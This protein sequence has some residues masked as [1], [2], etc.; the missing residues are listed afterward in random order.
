MERSERYRFGRFA[1]LG[2]IAGVY[3]AVCMALRAVFWIVDGGPSL[4][5]VGTALG[6]FSVGLLYDLAALAWIAVPFTLSALAWPDGRRGRIGHAT[7][8]VCLALG[9]AVG[10]AL[11]STGEVLFWNEFAARFNFIGVDYLV[12]TKEVTGNIAQSYPIGWLLAGALGAAAIVGGGLVPAVWRRARRRGPRLR[13][14]AAIAAVHAAVLCAVFF[15]LGEAPHRWLETPARAE[16]ASNGLYTLFRAFRN[17]DLSYARYYPTLPDDRVDAIL[18]EEREEESANADS[19]DRPS[20]FDGSRPNVVLISIESLGADYVGAF[21]GRPG[22]TPALD[23]LSAESLTFS[24]L[25]ATGLRTVRGLEALTLSIPPT[26]GRAVP[27]RT[28]H[29]GLPSLGGVLADHGYET[30]FLYGGYS[31]FDNM[32]AFFGDAGYTVIDR[33]DIPSAAIHHD[34]IWG[35]ADEDLFAKALDELD[36]RAGGTAPVFAHIMTTSNH[37]PYTYPEGRIDIPS[38]TGRDGAVKYTDWAI[39]RFLEAARTRPWFENTLFVLV[40]DHTSHGRGRTDLPPENY[41][42]PMWIYAPGKIAPRKIDWTASQIDV[43]PTILGLLGLPPEAGFFGQDVLA[44]RGGHQ[45]AFMANY[46][47]VGYMQDGLVVEISP[48]GAVTVRRAASGETVN[49]DDP[50]AASAIA[51]AIGYYQKAAEEIEARTR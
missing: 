23:R 48:P 4:H 38:H 1:V 24:R 17:N 40:A 16:V 26:P 18:A 42:I 44:A 50:S 10:L 15:G 7:T 51:E 9:G 2:P 25:Y 33:T 14:R 8:A 5:G 6:V 27:I 28:R 22:L 49:S 41:R 36:A 3:L 35:V 37:R 45:R 46:L 34:T 29:A 32:N 13:H 39:G 30:L 43:A 11:M 20:P 19:T 12:Y 21:G 31:Y 47:T